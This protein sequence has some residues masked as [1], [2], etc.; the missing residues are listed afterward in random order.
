M[1]MRDEC[2]ESKSKSGVEGQLCDQYESHQCNADEDVLIDG[3]GND[4]AIDDEHP[5][6][7]QHRNTARGSQAQHRHQRQIKYQCKNTDDRTADR[8]R[9][10]RLQESRPESRDL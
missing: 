1:C 2:S 6:L 10:H 4:V 9:R 7:Q 5:E 3:A 8:R